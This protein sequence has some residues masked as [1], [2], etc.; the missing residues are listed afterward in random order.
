MGGNR[1]KPEGTEFERILD[2][3]AR[4]GLHTLTREERQ[5]LERGSAGGGRGFPFR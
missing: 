1:G 4:E 3:V 2:K 5:V